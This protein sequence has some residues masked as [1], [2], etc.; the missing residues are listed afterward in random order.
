MNGELRTRSPERG[1]G[2]EPGRVAGDAVAALR[3][4]EALGHDQ[5]ILIAYHPIAPV[6]PYQALLYSR[7]WEHG[8][9]AVPLYDLAELDDLASLAASAG[10]RVVLHLHWTNKILEAAPDAD[11]ARAALERFVATLDR[12]LAA[13]GHL[14]WTV[15][16]VLPH[17]ATM[18]AL[19]AALQQ[20]IVD[21]CSVVHVLS[22]NAP[23]AVAEWFR[24]PAD[25]VLH[26]PHPNYIGAYPDSISRDAARWELGLSPDEI[27]YALLGA[28]KPYK[29]LAQLLDAFEIVSRRDGGPRRLLVAG[30]PSREPGVEEFL[31]RCALHPFISLHPRRIPGEDM[32]VFLRAADVVVLPHLRLLNSGVL[33]LALSFGVPVVGPAAGAI[34]ELVTPKIGRTF[35]PGDEEGLVVALL[36]ADELLTPAAREAAIRV[37]R[38][39]D[40]ARLSADFARGVAA[41]IRAPGP[42][43]V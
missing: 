3:H 10:A 34:S 30:M 8:L 7:L 12:F 27:V 17:G 9:A 28:I 1:R 38:K 42:T 19:E 41:R 6:N 32:Q 21:R 29:G 40:P 4:L 11:A 23:A 15:H 20:A 43:P 13:G 22:A 35:E 24:I 26:V 33:M 37:A 18:T 25:K 16:N 31:E 36:A 2:P 39:Y 14:I 5:P